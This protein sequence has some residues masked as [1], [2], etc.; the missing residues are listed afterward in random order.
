MAR[1]AALVERHQPLLAALAAH[2]QHALVAPRGRGRQAPPVRRRAGRW[3]RGLR[4]GN[5]PRGAQA[6]R[7]RLRLRPR[8]PA[9]L[10]QQPVDFGD[11]EN[12]RQR[13]A[14]LGPFEHRRRIVAAFSFGVEETVKLAQR[15]QPPRQRRGL[16][17]ALGERA[18][19]AAQVVGRRHWR[20]CGRRRARCA[21]RSAR[22]WR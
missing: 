20:C 2:H 7:R 21:V 6:L 4:A 10:R 9:R 5:E 19:I 11:R 8:G 17:A 16:E 22:S 3:R 15:R 12:F 18:E 14:A 13:A 1:L